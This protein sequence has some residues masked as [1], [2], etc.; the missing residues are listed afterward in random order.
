MR[1][2]RGWPDADDIYAGRC[3]GRSSNPISAKVTTTIDFA[4]DIN[5]Q[6]H[7]DQAVRGV[8]D[9]GLRILWCYGYYTT[10]AEQQL[11]HNI[12]SSPYKP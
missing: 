10:P 4:H 9:A 2:P 7:A 11:L 6:D 1:P 8:A 12:S 5:A 3:Q